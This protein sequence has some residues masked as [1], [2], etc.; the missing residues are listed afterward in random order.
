MEDII[1]NECD[2][3]IMKL[4]M[5]YYEIFKKFNFHDIV[6]YFIANKCNCESINA[7]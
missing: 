3:I 6:G 7:K 4:W 2:E 1:H 5:N